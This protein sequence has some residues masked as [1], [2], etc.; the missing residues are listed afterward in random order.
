MSD[1]P[2][3]FVA[4]GLDHHHVYHLVGGLMDAGAER[5]G[6]CRQ[7]SDPRPRRFSR[8]LCRLQAL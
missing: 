4:V 1:R 3:R 2:L 7:T 8:A 5:V 6:Y